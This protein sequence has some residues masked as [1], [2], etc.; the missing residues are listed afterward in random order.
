MSERTRTKILQTDLR[1]TD[2][3]SED[4][5]LIYSITRDPRIGSLYTMSNGR[6]LHITSQGS[7]NTFTQ[8]DIDNG[9]VEYHHMRGETTGT[10]IFKFSVSDMEGN[11]L[12]DQ[13]FFITILDDHSPPQ[14]L[15]NKEILIEEGGEF[16]ITTQYLSFT[17]DDSDTMSL[18]Y[19]IMEPPTLGHIQLKKNPGSPVR[20]FTQSDIVAGHVQFIHTSDSEAVLDSFKFMVSDGT[21]KVLCTFT[22]QVSPVDDSIPVVSIRTLRVQEG[23][24]KL[25]TDFDLKAVDEDTKENSLMF[26]ITREPRFGRIEHQSETEWKQTSVF[27]MTEIYENRVSYLHDGGET[28]Q[29]KFKFTLTDGSNDR[30]TMKPYNRVGQ[31]TVPLSEPQEFNIDIIP[32]DDDSPVIEVNIGLQFLE[33]LGSDA[34]NIITSNELKVVDE[35]TSPDKL[36]YV[37]RQTPQRGRLEKT[38]NPGVDIL[39]FTQEEI[40]NSV[41]RYVLT[42]PD[43]EY[44]DSFTFDIYDSKPN[45]I[46]SNMFYVTWSVVEFEYSLMNVTETAG[47]LHIPVKRYGNLKH[48]SV[49]TCYSQPGT[50]TTSEQGTR[51]GQQ[52]YVQYL[53]QVQFDEWQ[54]TKMC[55]IIINDDSIFEGR[56]TFYVELIQPTFTLI[57]RTKKTTVALT[58]MEDEPILQ[59]G[60]AEYYVNESESYLSATIVRTGDM[61][62][63]VSTICYTTSLTARGSPLDRLDSGSDYI[64]RGNSNSYRVIFPSGVTKATCDVKVIDDSINEA[65]EQFGLELSMPSYGAILGPISQAIVIIDGPNDES[66]I[67]FSADSYTFGEN[68]GTVDLEI[69][70]EGS[71]LSHASTVWC[72]TRLSN[73]PSAIS[74]QDYVPSSSQITFGPGQTTQRCELMILDD[75]L[76][77]HVEGDKTFIVFLSSAVSSSLQPPYTATIHITD[78][79]LDGM[80]KQFYKV[81]VNLFWSTI[82]YT[83]GRISLKRFV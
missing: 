18:L 13:D 59:F 26:T 63:T 81:F 48:Y 43:S 3:D 34:G 21:N 67:H 6:L 12:M 28:T 73:P 54:D 27:S 36:K 7:T 39:T 38:S 75:D 58:D 14:E 68:S 30:F 47:L 32:M 74:G 5:Y 60:H 23:V 76:D 82:R 41:V 42:N 71:D 44:E 50:A 11:V 79:D 61:S 70:R 15:T 25:I 22:I 77:P 24:R 29:D 17:D 62:S 37:V 49:V 53:G 16:T 57:G 83:L 78:S 20:E 2:V 64:S 10:V 31:Y 33:V 35:D 69:I 72:A 4:T 9:L 1:S 8:T 56:E 45:R 55:T 46:P 40:D 65:S 66:L 52:D 80:Y 19:T 51:P